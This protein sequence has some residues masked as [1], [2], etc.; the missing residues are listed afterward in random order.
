MPSIL[1]VDDCSVDRSL[2]G[3]L[4]RCIPDWKIQFANDGADAL[5]KIRAAPPDV[6]VTDLQMPYVDGLQLVQHVR[7]EW[8]E[9]PV[10]LIT[11]Q[12]SE[13]TALAALREGAAS[14]SPKS[15]MARD[16]V[17]T[18][19]QV[20]GISDRLQNANHA[21]WTQNGKASIDSV[22]TTACHACSPCQVSFDL[23]NNDQVIGRLIEYLQ[24]NLPEWAEEDAI[25]IAMALHEAIIN[26]MHH[27]NLEVGSGLRDECDNA[28]YQTIQSRKSQSPFSQ[29]RV[30]ISASFT[31]EEVWFCIA[32]DGPGFNPEGIAD[33]RE[34]SNLEKLSGRGLLLIRSFMD[35]VKHNA[36]G[37]EITMIKRR[38]RR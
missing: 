11:S 13:Q 2:I 28:Y 23:D 18:L 12:G 10:V 34:D 38:K 22:K 25:Q 4:L 3:G 33:P 27:G 5:R 8:S 16:L 36:A 26:A 21:E 20:L 7:Q 19:N 9:I 17:N 37:N 35:D 6:I 24:P 30:R 32:D 1:V 15:K 14:Y 31:D 29:R